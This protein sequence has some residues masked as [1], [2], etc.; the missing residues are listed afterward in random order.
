MLLRRLTTAQADADDRSF[1]A[2]RESA[3]VPTARVDP[4]KLGACLVILCVLVLIATTFRHYG[5][6][7]DE[8]AQNAY[9][10]HIY[11]F[12]ESGFRND[13]AL[14]VND[15]DDDGNLPYYGGSFDLTAALLDRVLPFGVYET[16]HLLGGFV[17]LLGLIISWSLGVRLGGASVG[18]LA[19]MLLATTPAYYGHMFI[20][21][22]DIPFAVAMAGLLLLFCV[23][24]EEWP[25][26]RW[27]T[28]ASLGI[29][30]GLALGTRVGAIIAAF[31]LLAPLLLWLLFTSRR[32]GWATALA[33]AGRGLGRLLPALPIAY[34]IMVVLWPWS[35][36]ELLNPL[37]ALLMFSSFPF[38]GQIP[39][40]GED[41]PATDLP[42]DYLLIF[43]AITLPE[44]MLIACAAALGEAGRWVLAGPRATLDRTGLQVVAVVT[45]A[46]FPII[47]CVVARPT[48][49]NGMRHFLFIL[50]PL[51]VLAALGVQRLARRLGIWAQR[52][53]LMAVA[54]TMGL[55]VCRMFELHP[56]QYLYYNDISGG[57]RAADGNYE[58]DY[59]GVSLAETTRKLAE[60]L[61]AHGEADPLH[62]W[63]VAV[64]GD[65]T[66]AA[67]FM[68]AFLNLVSEEEDADF[69]VSLA[70]CEPPAGGTI[71]AKTR[72]LGV[73]LSIAYD[74]RW[75]KREE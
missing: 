42:W 32:Q 27:P 35:A 45:A 62:P 70:D 75:S 33:D 10:E 69:I 63:S 61:A 28:V 11:S 16:R 67:Y 15:I 30:G 47:Y 52:G 59:W 24:L 49:Y 12:Y 2:V 21:P 48:A 4:L 23:V 7:W 54:V 56:L 38:E 34:V 51:A 71:V 8:S 40:A 72:R 17:G 44:S 6:S 13:A 36:Q 41:I 22:K 14:A 5:I 60:K 68:P 20:N 74:T 26:P 31:D 39:F 58:L 9:G 43:L 1:A 25:R 64:C 29:A 37:R 50:P 73:D 46:L 53:L 55:S 57:L 65:E 3:S 18:L 66:S 19:S